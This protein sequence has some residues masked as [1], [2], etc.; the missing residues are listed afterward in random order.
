MQNATIRT[1]VA[2]I[3][4]ALA[5]TALLALGYQQLSAMSATFSRVSEDQN[6]TLTTQLGN[7]TS[8]A[9]AEVVS[10]I[11]YSREGLDG[12]VFFDAQGRPRSSNG[13]L[14]AQMRRLGPQARQV[15]RTRRPV[16]L[17]AVPEGRDM[18]PTKLRPWSPDRTVQVTIIP[19][20]GGAVVAGF[21]MKWATGQMRR[22]AI[23][24][25]MALVGGALFICFGLLLMLG[26]MVTRPLGRLASEVRDLDRSDDVN[27]LSR[28]ATP[29]L[30][31]LAS[32]IWQ[33]HEDLTEA[34]RESSTDPLTGIAN[35]RAFQARLVPAVAAAS[36]S[37]EKLA[38]VALDLD[39]LKLINDSCGHVTG[40]RV[41]AAVAEQLT[42]LCGGR[43]LAARVGGDEF[44]ILC[45][46][47]DSASAEELAARV[48]GAVAAMSIERLAGVTVPGGMVPAVSFGVAELGGSVTTVEE[49]VQAADMALYERKFERPDRR[50]ARTERRAAVS[51]AHLDGAVRALV[52]AIDAK[53]TL[54][55]IH[56][57]TVAEIAVE[58]GRALRLD[59]ATVE[60][61]ARAAVLHDVGKIGIPDAILLKRG[62]LSDDEFQVMQQHPGLGYRMA[63][64][65]G[66][67]D[68]EASWVLHHHEYLDGSGYPHGLRGEEIPLG[69]R[70]ILVADA[71]EA[72]TSPNRPYRT[73]RTPEEAVGELRRYA[74]VQFDPAIVEVVASLVAAR[75]G[76]ALYPERARAAV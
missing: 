9:G 41:I 14:A 20:D 29:E 53:D 21:H 60:S 46:G 66:L 8:G 63:R 68:T 38:L 30:Q 61:V 52:L 70:I 47:R 64:S 7:A 34:L 2:L 25:S 59:V 18:R 22:R 1:R 49:L 13:G 48:A 36:A 51:S 12:V 56:C 27:K 23:S 73:A 45:P 40:D 67:S 5:F 3:A 32:D 10:V 19:Q 43:D 62:R 75:D 35:H 6:L 50:A 71:F 54:T 57:E 72:M 39:D 76:G 28:Q 65:V 55:R 37:G 17:F 33:M 4:T 11:P 15:V 24:T 26:R 16:Q 42:S 74:G 44:A 58:I 31:Q 69:A